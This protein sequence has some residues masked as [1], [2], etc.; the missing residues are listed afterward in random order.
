MAFETRTAR[1][2]SIK[3]AGTLHTQSE[4]LLRQAVQQPQRSQDTGTPPRCIKPC[5]PTQASPHDTRS[6]SCA[7]LLFLFRGT[8]CAHGS[9]GTDGP[10]AT[11]PQRPRR[12]QPRASTMAASSVY[13][14]MPPTQEM[15]S[16]ALAMYAQA[17]PTSSTRPHAF[18]QTTQ[19][20][21][22]PSSAH[23]ST[24]RQLSTPPAHSGSIHTP[25]SP[26]C[27]QTPTPPTCPVSA[28]G[29]PRGSLGGFSPVSLSGHNAPQHAHH[30]FGGLHTKHKTTHRAAHRAD[31]GLQGVSCPAPS[32]QPLQGC[33]TGLCSSM[34]S[35]S[36]PSCGITRMAQALRAVGPCC[37]LRPSAAAAGRTASVLPARRRSGRPAAPAAAAG[38][39]AAASEQATCPAA[40]A[41][42]GGP[43]R[44]LSGPA[45]VAQQ[46]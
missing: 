35:Q 15:V 16:A 33:R 18:L 6:R 22:C 38:A 32:P 24:H 40:A 1:G 34:S 5:N 3:G 17:C 26:R 13:A 7:L 41:G 21:L 39:A 4:G 46:H 42:S 19:R 23:A 27:L 12:P 36:A 20:W 11:Q 28:S 31:T 2:A 9:S 44:C 37:W 8:L 14:D 25:W 29:Q 43:R 30:P 45:A 10:A